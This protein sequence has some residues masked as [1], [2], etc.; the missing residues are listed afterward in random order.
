[1]HIRARHTRTHPSPY[2]PA[3]GRKMAAICSAVNCKFLVGAKVGARKAVRARAS[4]AAPAQA[5]ARDVFAPLRCAKKGKKKCMEAGKIFGRVCAGDCE[6]K[7]KAARV[8]CS[9]IACVQPP[10]DAGEGVAQGV[11]VWYI[12]CS[13]CFPGLLGSEGFRARV[14]PIALSLKYAKSP[15]SPSI[16][17]ISSPLKQQGRAPRQGCPHRPRRERAHRAPLLRGR[18]R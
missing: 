3:V 8:V 17:F 4:V 1:M 12:A 10:L 6:N 13:V 15:P 16:T 11:A 7:K 14:T 5:K 9:R 2:N 18:A